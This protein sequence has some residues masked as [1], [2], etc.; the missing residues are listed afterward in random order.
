[1]VGYY[2]MEQYNQGLDLQTSKEMFQFAICEALFMV[3]MGF[4]Y[5]FSWQVYSDPNYSQHVAQK[6]EVIAVDLKEVF[7][8]TF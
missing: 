4:S 8:I 7:D 5:F 1:M 3:S 2:L 6:P